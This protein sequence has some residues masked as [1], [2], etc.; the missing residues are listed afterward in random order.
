VKIG[1]ILGKP[2]QFG[3]IRPS[4]KLTKNYGKSMK[5]MGFTMI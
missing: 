1:K 2:S 3:R 4:G 5:I